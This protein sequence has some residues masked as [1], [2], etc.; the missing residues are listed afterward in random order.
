VQ[1]GSHENNLGTQREKEVTTRIADFKKGKASGVNNLSRGSKR[2]PDNIKGQL[3]HEE[4]PDANSR[5]GWRA[6]QFVP[7]PLQVGT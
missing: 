4:A 5:Q 6:H 3:D 7:Q 2:L 1:I